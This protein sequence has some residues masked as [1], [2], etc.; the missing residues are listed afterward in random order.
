V[1]RS[2]VAGAR[3]DADG[4]REG[5]DVRMRNISGVHKIVAAVVAVFV[6]LVAVGCSDMEFD[7]KRYKFAA[8][9]KKTAGFYIIHNGKYKIDEITKLD[10]NNV[11]NL[12]PKAPEMEVC[13]GWKGEVTKEGKEIIGCLFTIEKPGAVVGEEVTMTGKYEREPAVVETPIQATLEG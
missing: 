13:K 11:F 12:I 8:N 10:P 4:S 7:K 6:V 2:C 9:E 5:K 3:R 1:Y